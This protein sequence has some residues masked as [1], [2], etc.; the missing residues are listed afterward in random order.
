M[1]EK[2]NEIMNLL[3]E[4]HN[5]YIKLESTHPSDMPD[6]VNHFHILQDVLTRRVLRRDYPDIFVTVK[7]KNIDPELVIKG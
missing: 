1:D 2:E 3:V 4:A 5:K 6:W 7:N